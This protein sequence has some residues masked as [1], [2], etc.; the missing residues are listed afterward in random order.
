MQS[1]AVE[2]GSH[3]HLDLASQR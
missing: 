2:Q 1:L 3:R